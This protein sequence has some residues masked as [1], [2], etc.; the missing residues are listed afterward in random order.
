MVANMSSVTRN[1]ATT[2]IEQDTTSVARK[3]INK[4]FNR[5]MQSGL[6]HSMSL[7]GPFPIEGVSS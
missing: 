4:L 6:F 2:M 7:N 5:F 1:V 3:Y